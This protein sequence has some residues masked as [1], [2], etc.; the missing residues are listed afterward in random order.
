MARGCSHPVRPSTRL[1]A[2]AYP[3]GVIQQVLVTH[4]AGYLLRVAT[5]PW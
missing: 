3:G 2:P 1:L 5:S 4:V